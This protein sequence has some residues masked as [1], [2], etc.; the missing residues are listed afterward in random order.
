ME[1]RSEKL[2]WWTKIGYGLGDIFGGGSGT[3]ISFYY[4]YFLTDVVRITPALAGVVILISKIYD[5]ITD[6]FEGLLADRTRTRMGRRR[7]FLLAGIPLIFLSFFGLFYPANFPGEM[8][9][10]WYMLASYLFFSTVMSI[11]MLSYNALHSELTLDYDERTTL[12]SVRIFFSTLSS[13]V[14]ALAPMEIVKA[15]A[16]V[17]QGYTVMGLAFGLFF[18][19]P[20]LATVL[21][22]RERKEFQRPPEPFRWREAFIEPFLNRTFVGALLMY[23]LAFVA[24]DTVSSIIVYFMKYY[25]QRGGESNYVSGTLLVVQVLALPL[26]V[27]LSKKYGKQKAFLIGASIWSVLMLFSLGIHPGQPDPIIYIFAAMVGVGT[28]GVVVTMYAIFPDIPDVDELG[29]NQR[30]EG[31]Y[32]ALVTFMRKLSS[33]FAL[34]LVS[35]AIGWSGYVAPVE[36]VVN[37]A[38]RLVEQ[39]QPQSFITVL[40]IIFAVLPTVLV[41]GAALFALRYP[42]TPALHARLNRLLGKQ[43]TGEPVDEQEKRELTRLLIGGGS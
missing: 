36:Q 13:I 42:L 22:T 29:S 10:F 7:P 31:I 43:R 38:T 1:A 12:S 41:G 24:I 25:L 6:P 4:L 34:F 23:L 20:M 32:S 15:F 27:R 9:R 37:G 35:Q 11:V 2:S 18:A 39:A 28:G 17:R 5:S 14:A 40:R 30:R 19:L 16:D 3:L 21:A 33:A 8:S 26:F